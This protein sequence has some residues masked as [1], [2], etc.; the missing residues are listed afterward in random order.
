MKQRYFCSAKLAALVLAICIV[1]VN[2]QDSD[3]QLSTILQSV[4]KNINLM[5]EQIID[6]ISEEEILIEEFDN[7]GKKKKTINVL[8]EYRI[9]PEK[10]NMIHDCRIIEEI[11]ESLLPT[12]ILHEERTVIS[13]KENGKKINDFT[14]QF[15]AK[16]SSYVD[17]FILFDKQNEKCFDYKLKEVDKIGERAVYKIEIKQK[18]ADTGEKNTK[19]D[20]SISWNTKYEGFALIDAATMEVVQLNRDRFEI[21]YTRQYAIPITRKLKIITL[22]LGRYNVLTQYEYDKIKIN[23]RSMALPVSKT[24]ELFKENGQLDT[25][26]KYKYGKHKA[27]NVST[28]IKFN[29]VEK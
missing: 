8:S 23:D 14:E 12:G 6:L 21:N 18:E 25:V 24:I 2:A 1:P 3:I 28:K 22:P 11:N 16:G 5:R 9:F 29:A 10:A 13:I 19:Q 4:Q 26:Y 20:K 17:L 7:D 15:W 27:F